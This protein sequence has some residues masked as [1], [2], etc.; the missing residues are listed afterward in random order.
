MAAKLLLSMNNQ[1][2]GE[3][4]LD[5]ESIVI[6]RRPSSDIHLDDLAVSGSH[7]RILTI[8]KDSFLEDLGSTNGVFVNGQRIKKHP[9]Q[10]GDLISIGKHQLRYVRD[11]AGTLERDEA[12]MDASAVIRGKSAA[13]S[14]RA[15]LRMLTDQG[16]GKELGLQKALTTLGKP[17]V[18]VAAISRRP[19]G[20]FI[21]HVDGGKDNTAVPVVNG[22]P[23]G[24]RSYLLRHQDVIEI[25]GIKME[26]LKG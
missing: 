20:D 1:T 24:F 2:T 6:G 22:T 17:G 9:L 8:L 15:R 13:S 11:T 23:I 3:F 10:D 19:Q 5:R 26:Y 12:V 25:A 18:Q 16:R 4:V 14:G 21:V 7:A